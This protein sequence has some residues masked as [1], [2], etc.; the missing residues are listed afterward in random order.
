MLSLKTWRLCGLA[1]IL[2]LPFEIPVFIETSCFLKKAGCFYFK[3]EKSLKRIQSNSFHLL[4]TLRRLCSS[5]SK[6]SRLFCISKS[7]VRPFTFC[8]ICSDTLLSEIHFCAKCGIMKRKVWISPK[9]KLF[10]NLRWK[11]LEKWY[12]LSYNKNWQKNKRWSAPF[13]ERIGK[14][15]KIPCGPAAVDVESACWMSLGSRLGRQKPMWIREPEDLLHSPKTFL[16]VTGNVCRHRFYGLFVVAKTGSSWS[17]QLLFFYLL[18]RKPK[19]ETTEY[20]SWSASRRAA[21]GGKSLP[22]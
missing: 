3:A 6:R 2:N 8:G 17:F 7:F 20:R 16:P 5:F 19:S 11:L 9:N 10:M 4:S 1:G 15:V 13:G 12:F 22:A 21:Q 18:G 14:R